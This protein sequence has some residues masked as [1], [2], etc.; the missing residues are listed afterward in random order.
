MSL[1]LASLNE[2]QRLAVTTTERPLLLLAGAGSGKTRVITNRIAYLLDKG[3]PGSWIL[4]LTF[5]NKAAKEMNERVASL[6]GKRPKGVLITTFHSLCVRILR[7][8]ID[9]LG[10]QK[11]F[12]IFDTSS[13]QQCLKN[14]LEELDLDSSQANVKALF[15]EIMKHKGEGTLPE[16]LKQQQGNPMVQQIG[17]IYAEYNSHLKD[18]NALDFEDILYK[19]LELFDHHSEALEPVRDRWRYL[20]VDEY[21]DTNRVQY[22]IIKELA[23]KRRQLCV[24]GDDDQSIYGWRGADIR[25]ILDFQKDFPD[26][27]V[28]RLEQNYRSTQVILDAA[29]SVIENNSER[30]AKQLWTSDQ[31]GDKLTWVNA[32]NTQEEM[33]EVL[34]QM[35][36]FRISKSAKWSDCAFL[37]RSNFMSR[38]IEEALR[39]KGIPYQLVGGVKFFDRKEVQD[40]IAYMRFLHNPKDEVSLFRILNYPRRG[41]GKSSIEALGKMRS[42]HI[43]FYGVMQRAADLTDL[44]PRALASVESFVDIVEEHRLRLAQGESFA[45][46]FRNL[47]E[48]LDLKGELEKAEKDETA[49]EKKVTNL[50]E[51]INT[52]YLYGERREG[53]TL[54]DFL[55]YVSLFTDQDGMDDKVDKVNLLTVHAA[56]GLEFDFVALVGM[57]DGAFPNHKAVEGGAVEEERRLMYVALT[58]AKKRLVLSM[59]AARMIYGEWVNNLPSRFIQ[60]IRTD[61]FD[62]PPF[63]EENEEA[64]KA[65][66]ADARAKFMERFKKS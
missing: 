6:L 5:T 57:T 8:Y 34:H 46:V 63:G 22:R 38:A 16:T 47:F 56:K 29:N 54:N 4:A 28:I 3:M 42:S 62:K 14:V 60:E 26:C 40:C 2:P 1:D 52:L 44:S 18:Y 64:S 13:Q 50:L 10:Y 30:M 21:Q 33:D 31:S 20:M 41:I 58:R 37:Y 35:Q 51:F 27:E 15:F 61:L 55:D 66:A 11:D 19:A 59:P 7:E 48:D 43:G 24:V 49:R 36:V 45:E 65:R 32:T 17:Q 39:E 25:N 23:L 9:L 53:A 12:V